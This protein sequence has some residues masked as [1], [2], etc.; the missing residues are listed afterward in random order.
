MRSRAPSLLLPALLLA[1]CALQPGTG[2]ETPT[3]SART[4]ASAAGAQEPGTVD[5]VQAMQ[6][7][8]RVL[9]GT[10]VELGDDAFA[11]GDF[12]GAATH[13]SEANSLDPNSVSARD[14]LRR[15]QA[16]LSGH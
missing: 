12:Q 8:R 5:R 2:S 10:Y 1:A 7:K 4:P 11:R 14:G 13:Y 6:E 9:A 15:S 16:A 3:S